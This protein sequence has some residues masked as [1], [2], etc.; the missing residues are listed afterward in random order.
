ML[1]AFQSGGMELGAASLLVAP[2]TAAFFVA[3]LANLQT[4]IP[5]TQ[6]PED[7]VPAR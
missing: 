7:F 1:L 3:A 2:A 5:G 6:L 4:M